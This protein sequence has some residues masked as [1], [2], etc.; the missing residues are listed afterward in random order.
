MTIYSM[1]PVQ[2]LPSVGA[3]HVWFLCANL[4]AA[5]LTYNDGQTVDIEALRK[6]YPGECC[7]PLPKSGQ[8][9]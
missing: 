8:V 6:V 2:T 7:L 1:R 3:Y 4:H 9:R 5:F